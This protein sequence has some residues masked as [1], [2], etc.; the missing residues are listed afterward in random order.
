MAENPSPDLTGPASQLPALLSALDNAAKANATAAD[1]ARAFE[2]GCSLLGKIVDLIAA[3]GSGLKKLQEQGKGFA[4][5]IPKEDFAA[6]AKKEIELLRQLKFEED[7]LT[8]ASANIQATQG[9]LAKAE[10]F[11]P[12]K[13]VE[14]L[15]AF[16]DLLCAIEVYTAKE[17]MK[18]SKDLLLTVADGVFDVGLISADSIALT[19][20]G[21]TLGPFAFWGVA[22]GSAASIRSGVKGLGEK[23]RKTNEKLPGEIAEQKRARLKRRK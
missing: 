23:V 5:G 6:F 1:Q 7:A 14:A 17:G 10:K 9:A 8:R 4:I 11:D 22:L 2:L 21:A 15:K 18:F 16:R 3:D 13:A 20:A 19:V 12:D